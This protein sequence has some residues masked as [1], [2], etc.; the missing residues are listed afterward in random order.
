MTTEQTLGKR[1][2]WSAVLSGLGAVAAALW[3]VIQQS[4]SWGDILQALDSPGEWAVLGGAFVAAYKGTLKGSYGRKQK[5]ATLDSAD[6]VG[7]G[8]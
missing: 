8:G 3:L 2:N 7:K 4:S 5:P 6:P 1:I